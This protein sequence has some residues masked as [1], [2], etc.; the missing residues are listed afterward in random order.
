MKGL[1]LTVY[2]H[3][4]FNGCS[5]GGVSEQADNLT[6]VGV[7]IE[8]RNKPG[9]PHLAPLER[10]SQVFEPGP[11]APPVVLIVRD[12]RGEPCVHLEPL[13]GLGSWHMAGG[14]FA[15]GDSRINELLRQ[16]G[17]IFS[18]C[19][20]AIHDRAASKENGY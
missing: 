12:I 19:A 4:G 5:L 9:E 10:G 18:H 6:L 14:A 11:D 3:A 15:D 17:I 8:A 16:H 13:A 7:N 20:L 2:K 1:R